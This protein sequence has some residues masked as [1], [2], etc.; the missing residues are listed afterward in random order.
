VSL[1]EVVRFALRGVAANKLRSGLTVLGIL[2]GVAAVILLVAVGN[3]SAQ[4]VQ[5]S[6]EALGTNTITVSGGRPVGLSSHSTDLTLEIATALRDPLSAPDVKSVSPVV[7]ASQTATYAGTDHSIPSFVGTYP[8]YFEAT[9]NRVTAGGL[10]TD[11]DVTQ[12]SRV[13]VLGAT[14]AAE[15]F[16]GEVP[17]GKQINVG[18][19]VFT[20]IGVL[21]EKG[22]AGFADPNDIAIAPLTT[23]Q[24]ALTGFG[25]L[26]S[27]TV[28]A[29]SAD[30]VAAAQ[31]EITAILNERMSVTDSTNAPYRIQNAAQLL[32]TRTETAQTFTVLLG[33]VAG[34]SLLVGG[35]GI[36]NIMMVAVTERTREIGI[37]KALGAPRRVVLTQFLIE[38]TVLSVL[39]GGLGVA[40]ALIGGLFT[41]AGVKPVVVP[42]SVALALGVSVAIGLFFG[43]Y[44]ASRAAKLRP[45]DALRYE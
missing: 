31:A 24:R 35:I 28:Q 33:A 21:A 29:R 4:A 41:I 7:N 38:A 26:N 23:V 42:S 16:A 44:P 11:D 37:R 14:A 40:A 5:R 27:I 36:T 1:V 15:L 39:G 3:G 43:S 9:S 18:G 25:P 8:S 22:G 32:A 30:A 6:L 2:I 45:I 34:I 20:V 13:V 19:A 17:L 12:G 10:F